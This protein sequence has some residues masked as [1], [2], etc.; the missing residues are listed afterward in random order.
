MLF[1]RSTVATFI[2]TIAKNGRLKCPEVNI[3]T[4][5]F[6]GLNSTRLIRLGFF[7]GTNFFQVAAHEIGHSLGLSHSEVRSALMAPFY[8]GYEPNFKLHDDD[9]QGIQVS[10]RS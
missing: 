3:T 5:L 10:L 7:V 2:S 1:S 4:W 8:R 9:V 6:A